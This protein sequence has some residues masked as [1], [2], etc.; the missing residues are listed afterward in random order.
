MFG[1]GAGTMFPMT[2][3]QAIIRR[4]LPQLVKKGFFTFTAP[5]A[6]LTRPNSLAILGMAVLRGGLFQNLPRVV[7]P[8]V[9]IIALSPL[10]I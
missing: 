6:Q 1:L 2:A 10:K 7:K 4:T 5:R 3:L 9:Q 8:K